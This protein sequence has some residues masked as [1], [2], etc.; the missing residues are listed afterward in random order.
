MG[1]EIEGLEDHADL[2]PQA[3][4]FA[5]LLGQELAVDLDGPLLDGLQAV[6][7]AAQ[8]GLARSGGPDDGDDLTAVD[9]QGHVVERLE[10]A[11]ELAHVAH[12]HQRP[13]GGGGV[14]GDG[15]GISSGHEDLVSVVK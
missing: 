10:V 9:V 2:G 3:G 6:D 5:A 1:E 11:V 8:R 13:V 4:Q 12:A 15:G 7:G 14:S